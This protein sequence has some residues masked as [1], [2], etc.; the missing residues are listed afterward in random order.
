MMYAIAA[1]LDVVGNNTAADNFFVL[2][3][4]VI[5]TSVLFIIYAS[6]IFGLCLWRSIL[7]AEIDQMG[8]RLPG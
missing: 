8:E 6:I 3:Q 1:A 2:S 7:E 5:A 4:S